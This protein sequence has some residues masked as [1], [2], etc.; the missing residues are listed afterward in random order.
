MLVIPK[1]HKRK[2]NVALNDAFVVFRA[3]NGE[4]YSISRER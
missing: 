4:K 1:C 2:M 3:Q